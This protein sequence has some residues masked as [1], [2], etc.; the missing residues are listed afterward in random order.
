[1]WW[2]LPFRFAM[3]FFWLSRFVSNSSGVLRTDVGEAQLLELDHKL[4]NNTAAASFAPNINLWSQRKDDDAHSVQSLPDKVI[5]RGLYCGDDVKVKPRPLAAYRLNQPI[6]MWELGD[7][8][9]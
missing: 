9:F 5:E 4:R 8:R 3:T 1:V 2:R 7:L 6:R